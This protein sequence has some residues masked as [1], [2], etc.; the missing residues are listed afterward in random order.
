MDGGQEFY[1]AHSSNNQSSLAQIIHLFFHFGEKRY[2][3]PLFS[4]LHLFSTLSL[5]PLLY[6]LLCF[7]VNRSERRGSLVQASLAI[8]ARFRV[9]H[10]CAGPVRV[11]DMA[12]EQI[13]T[14]SE[15]ASAR[16]SKVVRSHDKHC[17]HPPKKETLYQSPS[18][19]SLHFMLPALFVTTTSTELAARLPHDAARLWR[20]SE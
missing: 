9:A 11:D 8:A 2:P 1:C 3:F 12:I 18:L 15:R 5:F 20:V 4:L 19:W 14:S 13:D 10:V 17:L 6:W 7:G 16:A